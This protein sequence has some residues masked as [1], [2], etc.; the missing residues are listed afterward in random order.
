MDRELQNLELNTNYIS[1][2]TSNEDYKKLRVTFNYSYTGDKNLDVYRKYDDGAYE[3]I[4]IG[5]LP[6]HVDANYSYDIDASELTAHQT[7]TY[8]LQTH[9]NEGDEPSSYSRDRRV[10]IKLDDVKP[11]VLNS[12][13]DL[14]SY[15]SAS[16][17]SNSSFRFEGK[18]KDDAS[19]VNK[20]YVKLYD[21]NDNTKTVTKEANGT[22]NWTLQV[23]KGDTDYADLL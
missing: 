11:A 10:T 17:T 21:L 15:P 22:T 5:T 3:V 8:K 1:S 12:G 20:V 16:E 9:E 23:I 18:A 19:G 7:I 2:T 4:D 14:I 13:S 6:K